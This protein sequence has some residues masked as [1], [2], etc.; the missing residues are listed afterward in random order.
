MLSAKYTIGDNVDYESVIRERFPK[1]NVEVIQ[2]DV[3]PIDDL[4]EYIT[5]DIVVYNPHLIIV[6]RNLIR[7]LV[8]INQQGK[9]YYLE[10]FE[11][12]DLEKI[13][14][15]IRKF[16]WRTNINIKILPDA[17]PDKEILQIKE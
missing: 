17:D 14:A 1:N 8:N 3:F 13:Y 6:Y 2:P 12:D 15:G 10:G 11:D 5:D 4:I 9:M 16:T 7:F